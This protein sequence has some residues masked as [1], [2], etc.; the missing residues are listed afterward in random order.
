MDGQD[1]CGE[2]HQGHNNEGPQVTGNEDLQ[3]DG[4]NSCQN[5]ADGGNQNNSDE[6]GQ[7]NNHG[8]GQQGEGEQEDQNGPGMEPSFPL[9]TAVVYVEGLL[10]ESQVLEV[11]P[12]NKGRQT[13]PQPME[14]VRGWRMRSH[15]PHHC[16]HLEL[17]RRSLP[18]S[19]NS[20]GVTTPETMTPATIPMK[21][22]LKTDMAPTSGAALSKMRS[23]ATFLHPN[24]N[25]AE[26]ARVLGVVEAQRQRQTAQILSLQQTKRSAAVEGPQQ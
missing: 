15:P 20:P 21:T 9:Q 17:D 12:S 24:R 19:L 13:Y 14:L 2:E 22:L 26:A 16:I 8:P 7:T 11:S 10:I 4:D 3:G 1:D 5:G 25:V 23:P 18:P 6:G